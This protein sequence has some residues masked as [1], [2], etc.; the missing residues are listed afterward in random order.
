MDTSKQNVLML[1]KAKEVQKLR[2][3]GKAWQEGDC[4]LTDKK[5]GRI[6]FASRHKDDTWM[7]YPHQLLAMIVDQYV[8]HRKMMVGFGYWCEE[9]GDI[10]YSLEQLCLAFV[11]KEKWGLVWNG[12]DWEV[13]NG[14]DAD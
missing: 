5:R 1:K 10:N 9:Y 13:Q 14:L 11:I 6:R 2:P 8:S 7:P 3:Y 12:E 4:F